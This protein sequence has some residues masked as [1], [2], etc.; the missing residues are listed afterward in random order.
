MVNSEP[1]TPSEDVNRLSQG[2]TWEE[3]PPGS[4]FRTLARTVTEADLIHFVTWAGF[5]E[6]LFFE[7][8]AGVTTGYEGRLI[9]A[10]MTYSIAEGLIIQTQAYS[11]T[12]LAFLGMELSVRQP[13]FVGDTLHAIVTTTEARPTSKPGRGLV[14]TNVSVRNQRDEEVLVFHPKRLML[15]A[16]NQSA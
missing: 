12:G 14:T 15:G 11:G 3:F 16:D 7:A 9:P 1:L 8:P 6:S 2:R 13:V 10:A 5:N 4:S